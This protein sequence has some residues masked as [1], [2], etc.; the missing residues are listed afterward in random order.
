MAIRNHCKNRDSFSL[1][2]VD[3][4]LIEYLI[5]QLDLDPGTSKL[6]YSYKDCDGEH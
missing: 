6:S 4:N 1:T 2:E 3:K 5:L